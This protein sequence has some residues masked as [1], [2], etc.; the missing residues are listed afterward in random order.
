MFKPLII[1]VVAAAAIAVPAA[2][3]CPIVFFPP[4]GASPLHANVVP[5]ANT[6]AHHLWY[7][8]GRS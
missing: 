6:S 2:S 7:A 3:A 5:V 8:G 4:T 1:S